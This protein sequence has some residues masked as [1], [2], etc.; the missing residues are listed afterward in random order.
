[1]DGR[2]I[3]SCSTPVASA[4]GKKIQT[5]EGLA[6]GEK[7][8]AIQEAFLAE[9]SMQCGYCTPGMVMSAFALLSANPEPSR[10]QIILG[11]NGNICRCGTYGR[12]IAAIERAARTMKGGGR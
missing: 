10:E 2:A 11:M 6:A 1:M 7:L 9:G 8:H 12:I 3:R 4:A 5:V